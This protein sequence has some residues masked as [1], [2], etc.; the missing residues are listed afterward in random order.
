M[1]IAL[2]AMNGISLSNP[3][4]QRRGMDTRSFAERWGAVASLPSLALLT[5]AGMTRGKHDYTYIEMDDIRDS[6]TLPRGY[7]LVAISTYTAHIIEAYELAERYRAIG[8]PVVMGGPHVSCLPDEAAAH[9]DAVLVGQ[10]EKC[11][12]QMLEDFEAGQ[13][14]QFYGR[15][16]E[17]FELKD[18]P[19]PAFELL[20]ISKYRRLTIETS[21]GCPYKCEFCAS[22]VLLTNLYRQ[23]PIEGVLAEVDRLL[24]IWKRPFIEFAD[25]NTFVNRKYWKKLL[26]ELAKRKIRWFAQADIS[27]AKD[28]ELLDLLRQSGCVQVLIGLESPDEK[29]LD[30]VELRS[31]WKKKQVAHYRDGVRFIQSH[32]IRVTGCFI[33]GLDTQGPDIFDSVYSFVEDTELFEVQLTVLTPFPGT[34]L[35]DRLKRENRLIGNG[36]WEKYTLYDVNYTPKTMTPAQLMDG[37]LDL[38]IKLYSDEFT[39]WRRKS[40]KKYWRAGLRRD[41]ANA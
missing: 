27:M 14:K 38:S 12:P 18:A 9:C 32:G 17:L 33:V 20:D 16:G 11:W 37:F 30:G 13:L 3:E 4:L 26:P 39:N 5:M 36:S 28:E 25:D 10:G 29:D 22:S 19:I 35:H 23:K 15:L 31:N 7:D 8:V 21:R 6:G 40:F 34:P 24:E 1:K 2:I 41:L